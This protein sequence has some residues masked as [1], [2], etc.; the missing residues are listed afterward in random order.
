MSKGN[1]KVSFEKVNGSGYFQ[2]P[3]DIA[4]IE[5]IRKEMP[6][7]KVISHLYRRDRNGSVTLLIFDEKLWTE[8]PVNKPQAFEKKQCVLVS[9]RHVK[10]LKRDR[11]EVRPGNSQR[12]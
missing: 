1:G 7:R 2:L 8:G 6:N 12:T 10:K 5:R 3:E 4:E 11:R 9:G